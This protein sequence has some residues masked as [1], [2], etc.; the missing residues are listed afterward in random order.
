MQA[1]KST[2]SDN[3][4]CMYIYGKHSYQTSILYY[5]TEYVCR[6][7]IQCIHIIQVYHVCACTIVSACGLLTWQAYKTG[8]VWTV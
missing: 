6:M 4:V 3:N 2:T 8:T 7:H 5:N 1:G